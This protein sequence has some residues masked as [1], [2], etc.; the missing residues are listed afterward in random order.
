M[1]GKLRTMGSSMKG[2]DRDL[3]SMRGDI[4]TMA[5]KIG[6]SFLFRGVK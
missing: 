1:D 6:G 4:H 2:L 5:H 3:R